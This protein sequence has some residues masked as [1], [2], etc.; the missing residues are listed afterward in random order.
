MFDLRYKCSDKV[1]REHYQHQRN[2]VGGGVCRG[3]IV[4]SR[5]S[6][7]SSERGGTCH[8]AGKRT[9][10]VEHR[11]LKDLFGKDIAEY[12]GYYGHERSGDEAEE[13]QH[14]AVFG[15]GDL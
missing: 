12:H 15:R 13:H 5:H 1:G 14:R 11:E 10:A 8:S 3:N 6:D 7:K 4:G 2:W 9:E